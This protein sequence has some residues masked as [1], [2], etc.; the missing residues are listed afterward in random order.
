[1]KGGKMDDITVIVAE[2]T[3]KEQEIKNSHIYKPM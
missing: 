2:V 1:M 3:N